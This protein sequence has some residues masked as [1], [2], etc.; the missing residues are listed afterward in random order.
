MKDRER[1][2]KIDKD[3]ERLQKMKKYEKSH[4][5]CKRSR[6]MIKDDIKS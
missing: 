6:N 1:S 4:E 3:D 2:Q 5:I